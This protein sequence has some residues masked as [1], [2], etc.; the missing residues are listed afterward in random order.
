MSSPTV[1]NKRESELE[2]SLKTSKH[3]PMH[4]QP[5]NLELTVVQEPKACKDLEARTGPA[6]PG[7]VWPHHWPVV[8]PGIPVTF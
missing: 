5:G 6:K 8:D 1:K 2:G 4:R 7:S 3:T